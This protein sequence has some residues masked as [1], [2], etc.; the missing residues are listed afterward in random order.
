VG[1]L[2]QLRS[3]KPLLSVLSAGKDNS[4]KKS[5][6]TKAGSKKWSRTRKR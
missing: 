3:L 6:A 2:E 1:R 4:K 5:R